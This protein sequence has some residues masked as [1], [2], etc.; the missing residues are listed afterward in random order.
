MISKLIAYFAKRSHD[1]RVQVALAALHGCLS[2]FGVGGT[3]AI[4]I[5]LR[6]MQP[7]KGK[8]NGNTNR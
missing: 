5:K 2:I 8:R 7:K 6:R 1:V 3:I 4:I